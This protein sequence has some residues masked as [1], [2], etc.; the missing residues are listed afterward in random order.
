MPRLA[1]EAVS[2]SGLYWTPR[3]KAKFDRCLPAGRACVI[4]V[5]KR[6]WSKHRQHLDW[7]DGRRPVHGLPSGLVYEL[8]S[9]RG[10][11]VLLQQLDS[12]LVLVD[13]GDH[14]VVP[15]YVAMKQAER[16][17]NLERRSAAPDFFTPGVE[18]PLLVHID[19]G[20]EP[21]FAEEIDNGWLSFLDDEQAAVAAEIF[22]NT[23]VAHFVPEQRTYP[24]LIHGGAGTGKTAI[25]A[26]LALQLKEVGVPT[27]LRCSNALAKHLKQ[28]AGLDTTALQ[29][30]IAPGSVLLVDDPP[31]ITQLRSWIDQAIEANCAAVVACFDPLQWRE[32]RAADRLDALGED[33]FPNRYYL[34]T[35]YRQ[36]AT[37]AQEANRL[38]TSIHENSS[39]RVAA[40]R[41]AADR[42][43]LR[44]IQAAYLTGLDFRK[45]GGRIHLYEGGLAANLR[46]EATRLA[47]RWDRWTDMPA[48]LML[49][50]RQRNTT[51]P[52]VKELTG[53][54]RLTRGL[55]Q[56]PDYR[57]LEFQSVWI[58]MSRELYARIKR[59]ETGLPTADW[60]ALRDLH[61][62]LTRA[63]DELVVFVA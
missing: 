10:H 45:P 51:F 47:G 12:N 24:F 27:R 57:G 22:T 9:T 2:P 19:D 13:L 6:A 30:E 34:K 60:E 14:D 58:L 11:R 56:T 37:V 33:E 3:A 21:Q 17:A 31:G 41:I 5:V 32:K 26:N 39:W 36:G 54:K 23:L 8:K 16:S 20:V 53:I 28:H 7:H 63:K 50:D 35:C 44:Q 43:F 59:G 55:H 48:L 15:E 40:D 46:R 4:R 38:M 18:H 49:E 42:A 29:D 25:L 62:A 1:K 61:I 52:K